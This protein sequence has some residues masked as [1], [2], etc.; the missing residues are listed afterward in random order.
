MSTLNAL[1]LSVL[2]FLAPTWAAAQ[3]APSSPE[4]PAINTDALVS[5]IEA[6]L[7]DLA[8]SWPGVPVISISDPNLQRQP[9]CADYEIF[10]P[11]RQTLRSRLNV[12]IRC[13]APQPWVGYTQVNVRIDGVYYV[14]A[15]SV[16]AGSVLSL[17]DILPQEGDLL[18]LPAGSLLDPGQLVGYI[19]TQRLA[20]RRP[21][22]ASALRSPDSIER[23]QRV[24]IEV[25]G[26]GFVASSDGQAMQG[27]EPGTQIQVKTASG[28]IV[29]ATVL[30][31][32]TVIIPM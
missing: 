4:S 24:K 13:L 31:A 19:T 27:G 10:L 15:R 11:G 26:L 5:D 30:N 21:I 32:Q 7:Q 25:R 1:G 2:L 9:A 17:D 23:G 28:Q 18:R 14:A 29:T 12:G 8:A 20:A 22:K 16:N 3:S 6:F